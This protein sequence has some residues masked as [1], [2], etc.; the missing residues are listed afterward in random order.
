MI[1]K[2]RLR[3]FFPQMYIFEVFLV[4]IHNAEISFR[5]KTGANR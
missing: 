2:R 3:R 4:T 5:Y 1:K